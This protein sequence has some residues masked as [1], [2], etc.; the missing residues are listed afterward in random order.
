VKQGHYKN[1]AKLQLFS[2][3][4]KKMSKKLPFSS[5]FNIFCQKSSPLRDVL[6]NK[7]YY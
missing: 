5:F 2:D 4:A 1:G 3:A 6:N 7:N